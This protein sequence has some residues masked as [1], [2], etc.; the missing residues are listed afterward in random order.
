MRAVNSPVHR[1]GTQ[2]SLSL[3]R[4]PSALSEDSGSIP[5]PDSGTTASIT[6][7]S[8]IEAR[9]KSTKSIRNF[10]I[11][12]E[13]YLN[14]HG[15]ATV[16]YKLQAVTNIKYKHFL[17]AGT[18][19]QQLSKRDLQVAEHVILTCPVFTE[20]KCAEDIYAKQGFDTVSIL[21]SNT[22]WL[23]LR[24]AG[25]SEQ[26]KNSRKG[27]QLRK[28]A[29][30]HINQTWNVL[31]DLL[32]DDFHLI[33]AHDI[34]KFCE[35]DLP[36]LAKKIT[37][38]QEFHTVFMPLYQKMLQSLYDKNFW[39]PSME[40]INKQIEKFVNPW[41]RENM[42]LTKEEYECLV[43]LLNRGVKVAGQDSAW[44][45]LFRELSLMQSQSTWNRFTHS[46]LWYLGCGSNSF[47]SRV[48]EMLQQI[49]HYTK[50]S[51]TNSTQYGALRY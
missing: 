48:A 32:S 1:A 38:S 30:L 47:P 23:C 19:L 41:C 44:K 13:Q 40:Y 7:V 24:Y 10:L 28:V 43:L 22:K 25:L 8:G 50:V 51:R 18:L 36:S 16:F 15:T 42:L 27:R 3:S 31:N 20:S 5:R 6:S 39:N 11:D 33:D 17:A 9:D 14:V 2:G 12:P 4:S 26:E 35:Q 34:L 29:R 49:R 37:H 45:S 46:M 21:I